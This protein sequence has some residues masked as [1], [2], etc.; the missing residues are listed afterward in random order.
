M[1]KV[2]LPVFF[3]F[4]FSCGN[5][6]QKEISLFDGHLYVLKSGE[7]EINKTA[8]EVKASDEL[9]S[10]FNKSNL[11]LFKAIKHKDYSTY[12]YIDLDSSIVK[13]NSYKTKHIANNTVI[14]YQHM[15]DSLSEITGI[16]YLKNNKFENRFSKDSIA[17][18][19]FIISNETHVQD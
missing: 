17:H 8:V 10:I 7:Q 13:E 4:F 6:S 11:I 2:T 15:V 5:V 3:Y 14:L 1:G 9:K 12:L 18:Q 19:R 16:T